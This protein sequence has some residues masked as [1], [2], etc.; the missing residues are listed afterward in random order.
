MVQRTSLRF[1]W[2]NINYI[3]SH[4]NRKYDCL[5]KTIW[6]YFIQQVHQKKTFNLNKYK[7]WVDF[8]H[9]LPRLKLHVR[10]ELFNLYFTFTH[11]VFLYRS[12]IFTTKYYDMSLL[13]LFIPI[14]LKINLIQWVY[15]SCLK[16]NLGNIMGMGPDNE[17]TRRY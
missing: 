1:L 12:P 11:P 16:S 2:W 7:K 5:C 13:L 3:R 10:A 15:F 17:N 4:Q 8:F 9:Y 6:C 14:L